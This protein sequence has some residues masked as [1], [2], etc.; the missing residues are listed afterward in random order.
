MDDQATFGVELYR[1]SYAEAV[2]NGWLS[3]YRIIAMGVG[4]QDAIDLANLLVR[5]ADEKAALE[6]EAA[7]RSRKPKSR[8]K[9]GARLPTT[10]DYLKGMAFALAMGGGAL[11]KDG[12]S[13]PLKSCI[14]F[15]NTI[16]RSKTMT[17]VLQS[18]A[19]RD[20]IAEQ[21][22]GTASCYGLEHLDASSPVAKRDEAK[23]RLAVAD[24]AEP[25][26]IL[27]VGIFGE[28]TDSPSLSAVAFLEPRKSPI[29]V[30]Q[31]VG[32]AM[33]RARGK[34]LGYIVVPVVIPP[35]V[36]AERHLAISDKHEG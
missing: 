2:R 3:D 11:A 23:R 21:T 6:A 22:A 19:V 34:D 10:G 30:V 18:D 9:R 24:T 32:R 36:D 20:W 17:A 15:L 16:A 33:R 25:R 26:G 5:D 14:G 8:Y 7:E 35:G 27:N 31:A 4:D 1:R 29:D 28:G 12:A 13:V